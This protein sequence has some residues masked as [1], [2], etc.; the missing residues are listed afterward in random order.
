[1]QEH[2]G[3]TSSSKSVVSA[4]LLRCRKL[5]LEGIPQTRASP[6][7]RNTRALSRRT[8]ELEVA[9]RDGGLEGV[10]LDESLPVLIGGGPFFPGGVIANGGCRSPL[11]HSRCVVQQFHQHHPRARHALPGQVRCRQLP[12]GLVAHVHAQRDQRL[13]RLD[14]GVPG[15]VVEGRH[16]R[17]VLGVDVE[18]QRHQLRHGLLPPVLRREMQRRPPVLLPRLDIRAEVDE[19]DDCGGVAVHGRVVERRA[20]A[21][22]G[23]LVLDVGL[24]VHVGPQLR[25]HLAHLG[26]AVESSIVQRRPLEVILAVDVSAEGRELLHGRQVA[27]QRRALQRP[28]PALLGVGEVGVG[29]LGHR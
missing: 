16:V 3:D 23:R 21:R 1:M 20:L 19:L 13:A 14:G 2:V 18:A 28:R 29:P 22:A 11:G 15:R 10:V 26:V 24:A 9:A 6:L 5:P 25:E 12:L 8:R 17:V 27:I 4:L 7:L